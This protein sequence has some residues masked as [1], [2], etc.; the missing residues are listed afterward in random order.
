MNVR[1]D[2]GRQ[3]LKLVK[4]H[5][6]KHHIFHKIF[7]KNTVKIS[8]SCMRNMASIISGHN[9][10]LMRKAAPAVP[11]CN[12]HD[13]EQCSLDGQ[14]LA[15]N[16]VYK[17]EITS[18]PGGEV[19]DYIGICSTTFKDRLSTHHTSFNHRKYIASTEL[20]KHIWNLKDSNKTYRIKWNLVK[21]VNGGG[22]SRNFCRLCVTEKLCIIEHPNRDKLINSNCISKCRHQNKNLLSH[23]GK[24]RRNDSMD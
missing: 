16:L 2:I 21:K 3:F 22:S 19:K 24:N 18:L 23:I 13:K 8:Y 20:S 1:T 4:I 10:S 15:K 17:A 14:C 12:C 6:H 11:T 7:N 5:F 9:K